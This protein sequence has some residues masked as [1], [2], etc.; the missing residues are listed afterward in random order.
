[1]AEGPSHLIAVALQV[2]VLLTVGSQHLGNL[3]S[4]GGLLCNTNH[5]IISLFDN[6]E[7]ANVSAK[8][9]RNNELRKKNKEKS[10]IRMT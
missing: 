4:H 1:V 5:H 6:R 2:A 10:A 8:V 9:Q 7:F 3:T